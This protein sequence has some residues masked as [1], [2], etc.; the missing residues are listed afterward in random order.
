MVY[1]CLLS[2]KE[3]YSDETTWPLC[4]ND[5]F[6]EWDTGVDVDQ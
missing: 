2:E 5:P 4:F 1:G 3:L 6:P